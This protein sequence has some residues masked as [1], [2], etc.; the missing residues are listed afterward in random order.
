MLSWLPIQVLVTSDSAKICYYKM[1]NQAAYCPM[2]VKHMKHIKGHQNRKTSR[3][4]VIH[5]LSFDLN[6][7][8]QNAAV[9]RPQTTVH[10]VIHSTFG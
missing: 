7:L 9:F 6:N 1:T 8:F 4:P 10:R 5:K 3:K 2:G